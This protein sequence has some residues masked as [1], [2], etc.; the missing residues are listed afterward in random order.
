MLHVVLPKYT[1]QLKKYHLVIAKPPF[2]VKAID[3]MH[4]ADRT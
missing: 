4:P 3:C 1:K 2:T